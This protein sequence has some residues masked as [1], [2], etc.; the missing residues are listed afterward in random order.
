MILGYP[1]NIPKNKL[2]LNMMEELNFFRSK[3]RLNPNL[4]IEMQIPKT[5]NHLDERQGNFASLRGWVCFQ[6]H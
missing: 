5:V 1:Q 6:T 2:I 4:D 3:A